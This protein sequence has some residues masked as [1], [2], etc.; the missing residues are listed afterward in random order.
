[1]P[2]GFRK[3]WPGHGIEAKGP[4]CESQTSLLQRT[5]QRSRHFTVSQPH[6][7]RRGGHCCQLL[8]QIRKLRPREVECL[9]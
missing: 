3:H 8:L 9:V 4:S 1:M 5:K 2:V 7:S 6:G